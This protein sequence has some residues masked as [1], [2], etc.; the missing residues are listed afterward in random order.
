M[1]RPSVAK[2]LSV[3]L[4]LPVCCILA[5][6]D[7]DVQILRAQCVARCYEKPDGLESHDLRAGE[8][9]RGQTGKWKEKPLKLSHDTGVALHMATVHSTGHCCPHQEAEMALAWQ[10]AEFSYC[11]SAGIADRGTQ[12]IHP[13]IHYPRPADYKVWV[14]GSMSHV[15]TEA[16]EDKSPAQTG[17]FSRQTSHH[18][19][20]RK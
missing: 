3:V 2:A 5:F 7:Y 19:E 11:R 4:I 14:W 16:T 18:Q 9:K 17:G 10:T 12:A 8:V 6:S 15:D 13:P 20:L 1:R